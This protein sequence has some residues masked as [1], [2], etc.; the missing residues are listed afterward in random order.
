[1]ITR[2]TCQKGNQ[3]V[4][5]SPGPFACRPAGGLANGGLPVTNK[6]SKIDPVVGSPDAGELASHP[7]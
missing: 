1:M 5:G 3:F 2:R 6:S 7:R 4:G